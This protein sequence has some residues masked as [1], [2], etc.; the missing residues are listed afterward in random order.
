M[1]KVGL[2]DLIEADAEVIRTDERVAKIIFITIISGTS[3][4]CLYFLL[5]NRGKICCKKRRV[6]D[7]P[8]G[9]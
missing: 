7:G 9:P 2:L 5:K 3:L 6:P 1:H 8:D 4:V